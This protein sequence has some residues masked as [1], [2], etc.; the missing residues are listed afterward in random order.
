VERSLQYAQ[1][2]E[3]RNRR[4]GVTMTDILPESRPR[5]RKGA[6]QTKDGWYIHIFCASCGKPYGMVPEKHITFAF[7]MCQPCAD[8]FGDDAHF[9]QEPDAVFWERV[10]LAVLEEKLEEASPVELLR[11]ADDQNNPL[12]KL[13]RERYAVL[14]KEA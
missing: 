6:V 8:K 3:R 12:G 13:L 14:S 11:C 4:S 10:R 7:A 2:R 9:Y 5:E 1:P